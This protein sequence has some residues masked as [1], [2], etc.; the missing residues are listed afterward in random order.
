MPP[1]RRLHTANAEFQLTASLLSNRR[2]RA[3]QR[4][5]V[6]EGVRAINEAVEHGW[7]IES[8]WY[9]AGRSPSAWARGLLDSGVAGTHYELDRHLMAQLS[10]REETSELLAVA[11]IPSD[12]LERIPVSQDT[13]VVAFD[14]P[15]S[16]GNLGSVV[17]SA[18]AFGAH[19]VVVTGHAADVYDPQAVRATVGSLFAVPVVRAGSMAE[20]RE[21]IERARRAVPD[22]R[23]VGTSARAT[24]PLEQAGLADATIVALG[25][26]TRGLSAAWQALCD[27]L[28]VIPM[29]REGISLNVAAAAAIVLYERR[30]RRRA[31]QE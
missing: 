21:W 23:V 11:E 22:L 13:L 1:T 7:P 18:D 24:M 3:R 25:N 15:V 12:D 14:R 8:F 27:E 19:G 17:R 26:E 31:A 2:Q 10:L 5:F 20:V 4:R 6:V 29:R 28:V 30:R 16:P 9:A